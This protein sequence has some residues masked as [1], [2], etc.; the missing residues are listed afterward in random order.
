MS[1]LSR[2]RIQAT[3]LGDL[4]LTAAD[5]HPDTDPVVLPYRRKTYA[6]LRDGALRRARSLRAMGW[7]ASARGWQ[8]MAS[9][10]SL[11]DMVTG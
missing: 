8:R 10:H 4:L 6:E 1:E 9:R 11:P 3:T 5:H 2:A 7:C